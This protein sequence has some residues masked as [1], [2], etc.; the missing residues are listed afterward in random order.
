MEN[1][2]ITLLKAQIHEE[3]F[4]CGWPSVSERAAMWRVNNCPYA[5]DRLLK[6]VI[7]LSDEKQLTSS[8]LTNDS[9]VIWTYRSEKSIGKNI[10]ATDLLNIISISD[11][12]AS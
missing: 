6:K 7:R 10:N 5:Y 1:G 9:Y 11:L 4:G 2:K 8:F 12:P 3:N